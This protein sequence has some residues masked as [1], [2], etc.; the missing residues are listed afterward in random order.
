MATVVSATEL[1]P[2]GEGKIEV[3]VSTR[4]RKGK[5]QKSVTVYSNDPTQPRFMLKVEGQVDVIAGFQPDRMD[6]KNVAKGS[7]TT[8]TV[9]IMARNPGQLKITEVTSSAPDKIKAELTDVDGKPAVMVTLTAGDKAGRISARITA[10]TNLKSPKEIQLYVYGQVSDDLVV[11]RSYAFFPAAKKSKGDSALAGSLSRLAS[12]FGKRSNLVRLT[13]SSLAGKPFAVTGVEDPDGAIISK[14]E[15]QA[16]ATHVYLMLA[17]QPSS[18]RGTLKIKTDRADQP[19]VEVR[20]GTA[21][22]IPMLNPKM[23]KAGQQPGLVRF[24]PKRNPKAMKRPPIPPQLRK[25]PS[26]MK[27]SSLRLK[28]QAPIKVKPKTH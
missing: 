11:D 19:V 26:K 16:D 10:K 15:K 13:V 1:P 2:G 24:D 21:G 22:N 28:P 6:L 17:R 9:S 3:K 25:L 27:P 23:V 20:Y 14:V 5:L 18:K 7:V 4:G 12:M 8:R